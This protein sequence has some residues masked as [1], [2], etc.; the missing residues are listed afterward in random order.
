[1]V[2]IFGEDLYSNK[3]LLPIFLELLGYSETKPFE[4]VG[5]YGEARYAV[6]LTIQKLGDQLPYLLFYYKE[7]YPL[8][9]STHF[10]R[11]FNTEHNLPKEFE[12]ILRKEL[13]HYVS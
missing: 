5:T 12:E 7:H 4:C 1:M 9:L 6:S 13:S 11:E 2:S 10:E 8:E 3:E